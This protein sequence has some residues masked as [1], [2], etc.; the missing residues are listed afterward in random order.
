MT[1][2][3]RREFLQG[4]VLVSALPLA[5]NASLLEAAS[6]ESAVNEVVL[7]TA[8]C[9]DR[10]AEGCRFAQTIAGLGV[11][12]RALRNGDV[13]GLYQE[14]DLLWRVQPAAVAGLTQFGPMLVLERLGRERG[15][16]MALRVEHQVQA[17]GTL[18]HAMT[19]A[20]DTLAFAEALQRHGVDWPVL[21]AA[22]ATRCAGEGRA[23]VARTVATPGGKPILARAPAA[24]EP[25]SVIHYYRP[26]TMQEGRGIPWDG[27]LFSWVIAPTART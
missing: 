15:L 23:P 22:L 6:A 19:G 11:P 4:G 20:P 26:F 16:R 12:V 27:P 24:D 13:T 2:T 14:L 7:H 5:I 21:I 25:E 8:V 3:N 18:S 9:D 10:Y 1:N 17:D